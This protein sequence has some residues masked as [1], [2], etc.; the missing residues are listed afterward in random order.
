MKKLKIF[1]A[2]PIHGME[3]K[4]EYRD[5]L[6]EIIES[7]GHTAIDAWQRE[8]EVYYRE[9]DN[10]WWLKAKPAEFIKRDLDDIE[11]CDI[12]VAY[13]PVLSAGTCME[14]FYAKMKG[15]ITV[16]ISSMRSLSPWIE[17]HA[18]YIFR[19]IE[20]FKKWLEDFTE[21]R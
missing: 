4:Q 3:H 18:D 15:K 17:I 5:I 9:G 20:E 12:L 11:A 6:R 8:K 1:I 21:N 14:L 16:V 7:R 10:K 19:T 2:G 13:L